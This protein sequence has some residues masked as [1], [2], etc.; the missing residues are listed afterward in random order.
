MSHVG[1]KLNP[2]TEYRLRRNELI[3]GSASLSTKFPALKTLRVNVEYFDSTGATPTG[4]MKYTVNLECGKS[5]FCVNCTHNDCVGGDYDL[6]RELEKAVS[7]KLKSLEGR[8]SCTGTRQNKDR[9]QDSP[10]Q[11]VLR[12]KLTLGY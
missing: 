1:R 5:L 8:M 6:S 3:D 9:K 12:Y 10:C 7:S 11:G 2:R 4:A